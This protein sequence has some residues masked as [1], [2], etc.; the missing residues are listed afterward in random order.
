MGNEMSLCGKCA[1][2]PTE[3]PKVGDI[4]KKIISEYSFIIDGFQIQD[5]LENEDDKR[6]VD[7][8]ANV[9]EYEKT[10]RKNGFRI[11]KFI[12]SKCAKYRRTR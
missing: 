10:I 4:S 3:C 1:L 11:E 6:Y 9:S 5:V 12:V 7:S 8:L 2:G